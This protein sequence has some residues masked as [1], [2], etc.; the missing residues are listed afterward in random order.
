MKDVLFLEML[1]CFGF[2]AFGFEAILRPSCYLTSAVD[3]IHHGPVIVPFLSNFSS[4]F[5]YAGGV[6][7]SK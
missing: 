4:L 6:L 2:C 7:V 3:K 5:S 1:F